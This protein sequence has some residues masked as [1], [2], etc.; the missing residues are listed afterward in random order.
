[1]VLWL[2]LIVLILILI[3]IVLISIV[4]KNKNLTSIIEQKELPTSKISERVVFLPDDLREKRDKEMI[5]YTF[6]VKS[7][8]IIPSPMTTRELQDRLVKIPTSELI[9]YGLS[10]VEKQ[11]LEDFYR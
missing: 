2:I 11:L 1:M 5:E 9:P 3:S 7:K 10:D 4:L 8:H 6:N